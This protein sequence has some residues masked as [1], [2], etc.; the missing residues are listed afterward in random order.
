[1]IAN[2]IDEAGESGMGYCMFHL[3]LRDGRALPGV[4][5][6]AVDFVNLPS[7]ETSDVIVDVRHERVDT[8][9]QYC[10][11]AADDHWCPYRLP[12]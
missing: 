4:T 10:R 9:S 6:N 1:M 12:E 5:G 11:P 3:V 8:R 7:G 2:R